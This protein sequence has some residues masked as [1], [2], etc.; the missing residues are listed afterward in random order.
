MP[1][2]DVAGDLLEFMGPP[3]DPNSPLTPVTVTQT[4][5]DTGAT[6]T[7]A[8]NVTALKRKSL[9]AVVPAGGGEIS[10]TTSSFRLWAEGLDFVPKARDV[11]ADADGVSWDIQDVSVEGFGGF[12]VCDPCV[13]VRT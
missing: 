11:I 12:Y 2:P 10:A 9:K 7:T 5:S 4:N 3:G 6:V 8:E 1:F 13:K